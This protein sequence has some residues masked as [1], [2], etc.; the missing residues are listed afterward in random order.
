MVALL[1]EDDLIRSD[2]GCWSAAGEV[3]E[4]P[5]PPSI[6]VL[7]AARLDL[8]PREERQVLER[9][10]VEGQRFR[11]SAVE[12][13]SDEPSL[14]IYGHARRARPEGA[15]PPVRRRTSSASAIC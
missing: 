11:R 12:R 2:D 1:L 9:A 13:L 14:R 6:Q 7:L 3:L 5:V 15:R 8:L 10:A 4:L